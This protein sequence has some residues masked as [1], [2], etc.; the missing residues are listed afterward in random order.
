MIRRKVSGKHFWNMQYALWKLLYR[1]W[2]GGRLHAI[3]PNQVTQVHTGKEGSLEIPIRN[4]VSIVGA[5]VWQASYNVRVHRR[6]V[7]VSTA[8]DVLLL[9]KVEYF[10]FFA[11]SRKGYFFPLPEKM[12]CTKILRM[13][14][15]KSQAPQTLITTG[16]W[17]RSWTN[18]VC[19]KFKH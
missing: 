15:I 5:I 11:A 19:Q 1:T 6:V 2:Y 17:F 12:I 10:W 13:L 4:G 7:R 8:T 16:R 9:L 18:N 3:K 14:T